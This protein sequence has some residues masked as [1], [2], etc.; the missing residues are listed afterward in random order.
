MVPVQMKK[1]EKEVKKESEVAQPQECMRGRHT[2]TMLSPK[3]HIIRM[4]GKS[5]QRK[6]F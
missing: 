4:V 2:L 5:K 1:E 6:L 3:R